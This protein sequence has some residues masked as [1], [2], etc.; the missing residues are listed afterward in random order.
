[1]HQGDV[2]YLTCAQRCCHCRCCLQRPPGPSPAAAGVEACHWPHVCPPWGLSASLLLPLLPPSSSCQLELSWPQGLASWRQLQGQGQLH[3]SRWG[4]AVRTV[5]WCCRCWSWWWWV[6]YSL[7]VAACRPSCRSVTGR[8]LARCRHA[9]RTEARG[10]ASSPPA[11]G[12][13]HHHFLSAVRCLTSSARK[14]VTCG[15]SSL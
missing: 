14:S 15:S 10:A 5:L 1:M 4:G 11:P 13:L 7:L 8:K 9:S 12:G 3:A 6:C 2:S